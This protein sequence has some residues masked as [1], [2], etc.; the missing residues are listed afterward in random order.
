[1]SPSEI[2]RLIEDHPG[3]PLRL[4]M[5]SGDEVIVRRPE[6]SVFLSLGMF[7]FDFEREG[8]RQLKNYRLISLPNVAIA[9]PI[10]SSPPSGGRTRKRRR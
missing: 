2:N 7:V 6:T 3:V 1:M 8:S 9:E 10:V 5:S 4:V